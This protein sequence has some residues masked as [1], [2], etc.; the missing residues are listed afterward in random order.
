MYHEIYIIRTK[1]FTLEH[2]IKN[3]CCKK[4]KKRLKK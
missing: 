1:Y 2:E 4:Q 3:E